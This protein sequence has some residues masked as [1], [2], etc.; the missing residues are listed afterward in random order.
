MVYQTS[1]KISQAFP[2]QIGI[3]EWI[4]YC[5]IAKPMEQLIELMIRYICMDWSMQSLWITRIWAKF[6]TIL[7]PCVG[8]PTVYQTSDEIS[9]A[10]PLQIGILEWI[11]YCE[12]AKPMEQGKMMVQ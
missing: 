5:E 9:Q 7:H 11:K 12:I 4:K 3:L 6:S 10:F 8:L 2:L 1:D